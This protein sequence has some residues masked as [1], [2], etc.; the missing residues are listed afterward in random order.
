[1]ATTI[2]LK[3]TH[4]HCPSIFGLRNEHFFF[5][6]AK[7]LI[8]YF[9]SF[10]TA[11]MTAADDTDDVFASSVAVTVSLSPYSTAFV[12]KQRA[13]PT[14]SLYPGSTSEA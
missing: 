10:T 13:Q 11:R 1:M 3:N 6:D 8:F 7:A 2:L 14:D 9:Q 5:A 4:Y 12:L